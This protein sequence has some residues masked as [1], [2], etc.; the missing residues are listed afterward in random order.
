MTDTRFSFGENVSCYA[1]HAN[2]SGLAEEVHG[3]RRLSPEAF[4]PAGRTFLNIGS[5]SGLHSSAAAQLGFES[6]RATDDDPQSV[7]TTRAL[8]EQLGIQNRVSTAH[9]DVSASPVSRPFDVVYTSS[10]LHH[11]RE[12]WRAMDAV[13]RGV[14]SGGQLIIAIYRRTP[15]RGVWTRIKCA[16]CKVPPWVQTAWST[17]ALRAAAWGA[18]GA[19]GRAFSLRPVFSEPSDQTRD[20]PM[21]P[22]AIDFLGPSLSGY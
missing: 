18:Q 2:D 12:M 14:A 10:V 6:V 16:Y 5:G 8:A 21:A 17:P 7:A 4:D 1:E 11:T 9:D 22:G 3:L 19:A 13:A 20:E 15:T